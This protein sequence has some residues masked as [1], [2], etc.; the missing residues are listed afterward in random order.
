MV[1][2]V[3]PGLDSRCC[4]A[5]DLRSALIVLVPGHACGWHASLQQHW[6]KQAARPDHTGRRGTSRVHAVRSL[7]FVAMRPLPERCTFFSYFSFVSRRIQRPIVVVMGFASG[8]KCA[9][10]IRID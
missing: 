4:A 7:A 9:L 3:A 10:F 6:R 2:S 5:D 1:R 8:R